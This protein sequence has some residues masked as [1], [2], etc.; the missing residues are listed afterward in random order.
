MNKELKMLLI[1]LGLL[2]GL[3]VY[4]YISQHYSCHEERYQNLSGEHSNS[5]CEWTK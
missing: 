5:V 2:I 1:S 4:I 3:V